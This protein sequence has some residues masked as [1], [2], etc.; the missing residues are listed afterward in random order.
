LQCTIVGFFARERSV[1][2]PIRPITPDEAA[3][4]FHTNATSFGHDPRPAEGLASTLQYADLS[5]SI[6][7]WDE[8]QVVGTAGTWTFEMTTPGGF[9][10]CG[11]L[12]W[13]GVLPS[14]RRKGILTAMMRYQLDQVRD[15]GEAIAALWASEAIIYGRFG[16]GLA[17]EGV[18]QL[19]IDRNRTEL[20]WAPA[21][22][23]R[24][25]YVDRDEA[26]A[27]W[28]AVWDRVRA[29]YPGMHNR[30]PGWWEHR[31]LRNPAW[32]PPP[33]FSSLFNVQYEEDG[34]VLGFARYR[35]KE[36]YENGVPTSVLSLNSLFATTDAAYSALW[37]HIFGVDLIGTIQ[38][39]WRPVDEP[40]Y[41]ML[42]DSRRLLHRPQDTLW[43]RIVDVARALEARRYASSGE[44]VIE[45]RDEFCPWNAGKYLLEG[46]PDGAK[47]SP[48]TREPEL[49]MTANELGALYLGG[50][51]AWPLARAGRIAG[52]ADAVAK[53]DAMFTWNPKPWAPEIW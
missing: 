53:A 40:L 18:E 31:V 7:V 28:P 9:V 48:T 49:S 20:R 27:K 12:T 1:D 37:Q 13:V 24:T 16:Y 11:G 42:T 46:G 22:S 21:F 19:T 23:G 39:D 15:R 36:Q 43:V 10:P 45:L 35:V 29:V 52:S 41:H 26:L 47:C 6:S 33:G 14:H 51:R 25:R 50:T 4:F 34:Q 17:A 44:L 3:P 8:K 32:P 30:T 2:Y 38:A 5:R